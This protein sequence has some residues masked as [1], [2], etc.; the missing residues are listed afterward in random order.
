MRDLVIKNDDIKR[1]LSYVLKHPMEFYRAIQCRKANKLNTKAPYELSDKAIQK[2]QKESLII[3]NRFSLSK[4]EK[5]TEGKWSKLTIDLAGETLNINVEQGIPWRTV[6]PDGEAVAALHRFIWLQRLMTE[7]LEDKTIIEGASEYAVRTILSWIREFMPDGGIEHIDDCHM[8]V[9]QTYSVAERVISW[10]YCL[11]M[12]TKKDMENE[13]ILSAIKE[14]LLFIAGHLEY[15]GE[16]YTGNHLS[17]DGRAIFIGGCV[18]QSKELMDFGLR[19]MLEEAKRIITDGIFLREGSA[20]YQFLI[21]RNYM[22]AMLFAKKYENME[23]ERELKAIVEK[24]AEGCK[25]F[26][27]EDTSK[28]WDIPRIGDIS[29]D[30]TPEWLM[31]VPCVSVCVMENRTSE[32]KFPETI[33]WHT[34]VCALF[35]LKKNG[36]KELANSFQDTGTHCFQDWVRVNKGD[37]IFFSHINQSC[38][39]YTLGHAHQDSGGI[40]L[41]HKGRRIVIDTGRKRYLDVTQGGKGKEWFGHSM[42]VVDDINPFV[43]S[44][45]FY[46]SQY[47]IDISKE[48]PVFCVEDDHTI[49]IKNHG[50]ERIRGVGCHQR[51][52]CIQEKTIKISDSVDGKGKHELT[53]LFHL[54]YQVKKIADG[55]EFIVEDEKYLVQIP[56]NVTHS[57][58]MY[59]SES[60]LS[61]ASDIYG[62]EYDISTIVCKVSV[63]LPWKC[64]TVIRFEG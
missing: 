28:M 62:L 2:I 53:I 13:T 9:W 29:P 10:I 5:K 51:S 61:T 34:L 19:I 63:Y 26:L 4:T 1:Y 21:T 33:G 31:G 41:F 14:Q 6:F 8:E 25:F 15:H 24:L 23:A 11:V 42:L 7:A 56:N 55:Y 36:K 12:S 46:S 18:F 44:R 39:P 59:G 16:I 3:E 20:H 52:V 58:V 40:V 32:E 22:E 35:D 47:L 54:P 50:Y 17:N 38:H 64:E 45:G 37:W 60:L 57:N 49:V 30:C 27:Y 48:A 43:T